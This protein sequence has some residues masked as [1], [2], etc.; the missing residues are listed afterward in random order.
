MAFHPSKPELA[1]AFSSA[2]LRVFD[3]EKSELAH[4]LRQHSAPVCACLFK[5][6]GDVLL[7]LGTAHTSNSRGLLYHIAGSVDFQVH[8]NGRVS[9]GRQP[10][11]RSFTASIVVHIAAQQ[12]YT[13][14][15]SWLGGPLCCSASL[16]ILSQAT[17][18]LHANA[19]VRSQMSTDES[20]IGSFISKQES[21]SC[22]QMQTCAPRYPSAIAWQAHGLWQNEARN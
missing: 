11:Q 9:L 1:A 16:V 3:T 20:Q 19:Q 2:L 15:A 5:P 13:S 7:T 10:R 21:S 22:T 12:Q 14:T 17:V 18:P 4:T 6:L 8:Q